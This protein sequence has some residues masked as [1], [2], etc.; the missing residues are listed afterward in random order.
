ML[1]ILY[2]C[3]VFTFLIK[4][5]KSYTVYQFSSLSYIYIYMYVCINFQ[6]SPIRES[7]RKLGVLFKERGLCVCI[8]TID[9]INLIKNI[10]VV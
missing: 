9:I 5:I 8:D 4:S 1:Y 2:L 6:Y 3:N 10:L 7:E